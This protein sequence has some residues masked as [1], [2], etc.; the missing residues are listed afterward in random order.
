MK[1]S[2]LNS[3]VLVAVS[4]VIFDA[5]SEVLADLPLLD[6]ISIDGITWSFGQ[7]VPVG[8]FV[9]GDYYVV[10]GVTV[11]SVFPAPTSERNGSVVNLPVN[12]QEASGFD[13]RVSSNRYRVNLRADFPLIMKP[14]DALISS[15]SLETIGSIE[16]WLRE[17]NNV[18]ERKVR[19]C[20]GGAKR[21]KI[22][23]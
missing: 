12:S 2:A 7:K 1:A 4:L 17:G 20:R 9:N 3:A 14:G 23:F 11:A 16:P 19:C 10:G 15:I 13:S 18:H 5:T 6:K 22:L 8:R 21:L